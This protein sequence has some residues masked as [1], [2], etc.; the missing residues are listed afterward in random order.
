MPM[1]EASVKNSSKTVKLH[2]GCGG[3]YLPG[4]IHVDIRALPNVDV[5]APLEDLS[6]FP[7]NSA[8][9]IYHCAVMEHI[10]RWDTVNV[11]KEWYRV[12][13]PGGTLR[14]SV[15]N[16]E[17]IVQAYSKWGEM[18]MLLGLLYGRQDYDENA[19]YTMLDRK[20]FT[21]CLA[22]AGFTDFRDYDWRDFLPEGYD[23]FSR[24][25]LPHMDFDNGMLMML[26]I[27]ATKP[28]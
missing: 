21:K 10:G 16:F 27:D 2:L 8:D 12:L 15:P 23:D 17:A 14:S 28:A 6:V 26:N 24:S 19:H 22:A 9:L 20:Y 11:L 5:V 4:F 7:D 3:R 18:E 1:A 13:K 25:Y